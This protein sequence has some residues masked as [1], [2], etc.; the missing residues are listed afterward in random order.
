MLWK[1]IIQQ[2]FQL[3]SLPHKSSGIHLSKCQ[4]K[5]KIGICHYEKMAAMLQKLISLKIFNQGR[6]LILN[7]ETEPRFPH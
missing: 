6:L 3:P 2:N 1:L 5:W 7:V 4:W